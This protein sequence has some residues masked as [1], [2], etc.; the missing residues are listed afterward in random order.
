[1]SKKLAI[2]VPLSWSH[3]PSM[4]FLS[5]N[6]MIMH[7]VEKYLVNLFVSNFSLIDRAREVL[8][9]TALKSDPDYILWLD[10]DQ[11]YP[12]DTVHVLAAHVDNGHQIVG[13]VTPD[14]R[15]QTPLIYKFHNENGIG[16]RWVDIELNQGLVKVD[17]MGFGGIMTSPEALRK[18]GTPLFQRKWDNETGALVGEDL[19]FYNRAKAAGI[20]VYCDTNLHYSHMVA[21]P[22]KCKGDVA[23]TGVEF[24]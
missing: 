22:V 3:V 15:T 24:L 21:Y 23:A 14:K 19:C 5:F 9:E 20:D 2:C 12:K 11:L 17:A 13:G 6:Q 7:T 1:M 16:D 18:M 10:A 4:F 8:A